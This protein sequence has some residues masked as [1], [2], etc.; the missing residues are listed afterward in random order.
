MPPNIVLPQHTDPVLPVD[1]MAG[2]PD[3]VEPYTLGD[4]VLYVSTGRRLS[5]LTLA[6][7][8]MNPMS[9]MPVVVPVGTFAGAD[10]SGRGIGD[11]AIRTDGYVFGVQSAAQGDQ[12]QNAGQLLNINPNDAS[13]IRVGLDHIVEED[14]ANPMPEQLS[15][16]TIDAI[17][18]QRFDIDAQPGAS[19]GNSEHYA[20]YYSVRGGTGRC[21]ISR[22]RRTA[23]PPTTPRFG[24]RS[25]ATR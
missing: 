11:I 14:P 13:L 17:A 1:P 19:D 10:D 25:A 4:I 2:L 8:P 6:P 16:D 3:V 23:K 12:D 22:T 21:C 9:G 24:G 15:A 5:A 18:Y 20:L 7:D